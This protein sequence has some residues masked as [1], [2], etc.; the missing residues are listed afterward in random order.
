MISTSEEWKNLLSTD[1][2]LPE[3][4]VN[5]VC[6]DDVTGTSDTSQFSVSSNSLAAISNLQSFLKSADSVAQR[7][8]RKIATLEWNFLNLDGKV[9]VANNNTGVNRYVSNSVSDEN[10]AFTTAPTIT[11][12]YSGPPAGTLFPKYVTLKFD[13]YAGTYPTSIKLNNSSN[14]SIN[15]YDDTYKIVRNSESTTTGTTLYINSWSMPFRRARISE[16]LLGARLFFDKPQ[17]SKF[18]HQRTTDMVCAELPQNDCSFSVL[19]LD[20]EWDANNP[21]AKL[22]S[23]VNNNSV[24]KI[25]YGYK[26]STGWEYILTDTLLLKSIDRPENG[27]EANFVLESDINRAIETFLN[28]T[29]DND[30]Y[31]WT[32]YSSLLNYIAEKTGFSFNT[33]NINN[34]FFNASAK[35]YLCYVFRGQAQTGEKNTIYSDSEYYSRKMNEWLQLLSATMNAYIRKNPNGTYSLIGLLNFS[36]GAFISSTTVDVI[37]AINCF[38]YPE[39]ENLK[40]IKKV[41][42]KTKPIDKDECL[43]DRDHTVNL[44][45]G[46]RYTYPKYRYSSN[47]NDS[48]VKQSAENHLISVFPNNDSEYGNYDIF[49]FQVS[50]NMHGKYARYLYRFISEAMKIKVNCRLNPAWQVGDLIGVQLKNGQTAKGFIIDLDIEYAGYPKGNVTILA[51]KLL[52]P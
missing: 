3:S 24:F 44:D 34:N 33:S 37:N 11:I 25:Y 15:S 17:I 42:V 5:V 22:Y 4:D 27:M 45:Q 50:D 39:I 47:F 23:L 41:V 14:I 1:E 13:N 7:T 30:S 51:P 10:G 26:L 21:N 20:C 40:K 9:V 35:T 48:G 18:K 32:K 28:T 38:E 43:E 19:D 46:S 8:P 16:F 29:S 36:T 52:N 12:G 6:N 49:G 31:T 2:L